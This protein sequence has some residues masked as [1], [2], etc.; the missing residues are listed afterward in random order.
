M[1]ICDPEA[2]QR[3]H[4]ALPN[5]K[6]IISLRNPVSR[7]YSHYRMGIA[8]RHLSISLDEAI[9][10]DDVALIKRSRYSSQI[11]LWMN[12]FPRNQIKIIFFEDLSSDPLSC[13]SEILSYL[14]VDVSVA[15]QL[16]QT[17][18]SNAAATYRSA[19]IYNNGVRLSRAM[20]NFPVASTMAKQLKRV[21][22]YDK[23]KNM[24]RVE[25]GYEPLDDETRARLVQCFRDDV[26]MLRGEL[27]QKELPW[28]D[29]VY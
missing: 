15:S 1:Y 16:A 7:T 19:A 5:A 6:I 22:V 26:E 13:V 23:I 28:N 11:K 4:D 9:D 3:I 14:N 27:K 24:N 29:F 20:R 25:S 21:G 17:G 18:K 10:R 2:P 12:L 8:K